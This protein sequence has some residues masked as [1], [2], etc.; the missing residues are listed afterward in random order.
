MSETQ[1]LVV[2]R[3]LHFSYRTESS[4][5]LGLGGRRPI[6]ALAGLDLTLAA[7]R[8]TGLLGESGSGKS[9]LALVLSG[10][11]ELDRG[12]LIIAGEAV[13]KLHGNDRRRAFRKV[14]VVPQFAADA[15]QLDQTV[16][17]QFTDRLRRHGVA[18]LE[19]A[20]RIRQAL[21]QVR[22]PTHFADRTPD[23]MS[24][25]ERQRVAIARALTQRPKLLVLDEPVAAVDLRLQES[26]VEMLLGLRRDGLALLWIS[27]DLTTLRRVSEELAVLYRGRVVEAG[28]AAAI[29][30]RPVHPYTQRLLAP[31]SELE[32]S[33]D[34]LVLPKGCAFHPLCKFA[35][36]A[37]NLN[38]PSL[39]HSNDRQVACPEVQG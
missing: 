19:A 7:S 15:L 32:R 8:V 39:R 26:L 5:L 16:L 13:H 11:A 38:V 3:D 24:G 12:E 31:D 35:T 23:A 28:P 1:P 10:N 6:K 17:K 37:C 34:P 4:G 9:A 2:A 14:G 36:P 25:G 18:E 29:W 27:H 21:E 20:T 33:P 22:L 30:E